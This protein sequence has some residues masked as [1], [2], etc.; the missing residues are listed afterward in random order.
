MALRVTHLGTA[1]VILELGPLRM[2][3]IRRGDKLALR[4]RDHGAP[5]L[6][7][8]SGV[9]R[10]AIANQNARGRVAKRFAPTRARRR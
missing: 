10:F 6:A 2:H 9:D 5:A 1:T 7:S 8:F 4:V 3:L